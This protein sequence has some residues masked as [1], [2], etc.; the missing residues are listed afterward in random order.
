MSASLVGP[1]GPG[2]ILP[3]SS[4]PRP[5]SMMIQGAQCFRTADAVWSHPVLALVGHQGVVRLK[6]EV[7]V[8]KGGVKAEVLQPGLQCGHVVAVHRRPE[9]MRQ[10]AR[11]QPVGGFFEGPIRGL[12]D[13]AVHQQTTAL[14]EG[15]DRMIEFVVENVERNVPAGAQILVLVF[16]QPERGKC[17]A[18]LDYCRTP[19]AATQSVSRARTWSRHGK[20]C[21][22]RSSGSGNVSESSRVTNSSRYTT[23][24]SSF[25]NAALLLA[26]TMR[27]TGWPSWNRIS[28]G[29][30]ETW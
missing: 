4:P 18:N 22:R 16:H 9:L 12:A 17:L 13:D 14:L 8:H 3:L 2:T 23:S 10:D 27:F 21:R 1:W 11:A 6:P 7:A 19:V 15:P 25:S 5:G 28:V 26:P 29:I 30:D 24:E 20:H